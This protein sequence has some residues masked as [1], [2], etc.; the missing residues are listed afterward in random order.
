[1][2][3]SAMREITEIGADT[4]SEAYQRLAREIAAAHPDPTSLVIVGIANGGIPFAQRLAHELSTYL[5]AA[6]PNGRINI[7]FHR[8]DIGTNPIPLPKSRTNIPCDVSGRTVI[9]ADDVI[10][11]GRTIRA[12]LN[13][14]FDAGRPAK[15]ELAILCDRGGRRLPI[16]PDY[17]GL[18]TQAAPGETIRA[19]LHPD[20]PHADRLVI[21]QS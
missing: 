9:L 17:L 10:A 7:T 14:L 20:Q 6:I 21:V 3:L 11:S 4:I 18:S 12:A 13:E 1:M 2:T 8:D 15:V 19:E 16:Q 5:G